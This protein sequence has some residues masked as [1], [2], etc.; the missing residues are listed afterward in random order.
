M[1]LAVFSD[2]HGNLPAL[3]AVLADVAFHRPDAVWYVGDFVG[4]GPW[5][6]ECVRRIAEAGI[7]AVYGNYD[8]K[9]LKYPRKVEVWARTKDPRKTGAFRHAFE[10]LSAES[11]AC[12]AGLPETYR[13]EW[14]GVR[15]LMVHSAPDSPRVGIF[16]D[17]AQTRLGVIAS[18]WA[19]D[20]VLTGHTHLPCVLRTARGAT[21]VN[22]G[23]AGRPGDGDPRATWALIEIEGGT[24]PRVTIERT[25]YPVE[26][27]VAETLR[28]PGLSPDF[29]ELYPRGQASF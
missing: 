24:A 15:A 3:E 13:A 25:V 19:A 20:L 9:T 1:R 18:Q 2:I 8:R 11:R 10:G 23:S 26:E 28:T 29:A 7:P 21:F 6:E 16:P 5:P 12:L 27:I 17:T 4:Y 14:E 22:V